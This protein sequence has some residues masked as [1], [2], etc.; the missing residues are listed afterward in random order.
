MPLLRLFRQFIL[1]S[2]GRGKARSAAAVLGVAVGVAVMVAIRLANT[3]VTDAFRA[4]VDAV[5]GEASLRIRGAAGR[6]DELRLPEIDWLADE[7]GAVLSPV[8]T[9]HAMLVDDRLA[10]RTDEVFPRGELL[11]VL[12]V[13]VLADFDLRDYQVL[14]TSA[15]DTRN[16]REVLAL[17]DD[18]RSII[19]TEK[20]LRRHGLRVGD[21]VRLTFASTPDTYTIRG[22]LLNRGPAR[23]LDGNFALMDIA[24]AQLAADRLGL[25]DH[26]DVRLGEGED[27]DAALSQIQQRLPTGLVVERPD[28]SAGR[29]DT[30]IDAFQFN[31]EALSA[32]ALVV[33]LFL[34]YNT[35]A[36]SVAARRDEIGLLQAA[37]AGRRA[38]LAL[39]L[40][41]ALVLAAAGLLLGLP[42]GRLLAS[43]AVRGA[44]QTVETFYIAGVAEASASQLQMSLGDVLT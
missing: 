43:Y 13:D 26:V 5:G 37:G 12:G 28:A 4:A 15:G 39:F 7:R 14:K 27:L 44:A 31:L 32:V 11:Q 10:E 24:A 2:L 34:V 21:G 40:G 18:P 25:V 41:E 19:L 16:A 23:T 17:L 33:G 35:V 42:L 30:M 29:T 36:M 8:I 9:T 38:V 1:R 3:S 6:F 22:V 20:F